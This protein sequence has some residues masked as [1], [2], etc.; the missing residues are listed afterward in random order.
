MTV[1]SNT[2]LSIDKVVFTPSSDLDLSNLEISKTTATA[3]TSTISNVTKVLSFSNKFSYTGLIN[4][5]YLDA[6]LNGLTEADL[7]F[8]YYNN[9][10]WYPQINSSVITETNTVSYT[11]TNDNFDII[12]LQ[13][14]NKVT[15]T[16][17]TSDLTKTYGDNDFS[18]DSSVLSS[19]SDGEITYRSSNSSIASITGSTVSILSAGSVVISANQTST[20]DFEAGTTSFTLTILK[21]DPGLSISNSSKI[22]NDTDFSISA[23]SSSGGAIAYLIADSSVATISGTTV[24]II[25]AGSTII[26]VSQSATTNYNSSTATATLTVSKDSPTLSGLS[27]MT[28]NYGDSDFSLSASSSSTGAITYS[29][30]DNSVATIS[31]TTVTIVGAGSAII[32]VLQVADNNYNSATLTA[33]LTVSKDSPTLSGLSDMTKNYGD[34]DFSLSASSP[35]TGAIMYSSSDTSVATI[36][37]TT[38]TIVGAGS[39]IITASQTADDNYNSATTTVTLTVSKDSPTLSGLSNIS[40]TYGD[41]DFSL[42]ASSSSTGAIT[43]SSSDNSVATISGTTVTIVGAGSAIITASQTA[44]DNY[45][46][47]TITASLT[48]QKDEAPI[49]GYDNITNYLHD[50]TISL[51]ASSSSTALIT[52]SSSD[53]SIATISGST[54]IPKSAGEA[55][56]TI[57]QVGDQNYLSSMASFSLT[58]LSGNPEIS[59]FNDIDKTYNDPTFELNASSTSSGTISYSS[60]NS[61]VATI[62]GTTVSI[63]GAGTATILLEQDS[64]DTYLAATQSI[65]LRVAKDDPTILFE[66]LTK[67]YN[68]NDFSLSATSSSTGSITFSSSDTSVASISGSTVTIVGAGNA[69][70]TAS[71]AADSNYN[72]A[73]NTASLTVI[74]DIPTI[75]TSNIVRSYDDEDF[76]ITTD[77]VSSTSSAGFFYTSSNNSVATVSGDT[78]SIVSGGSTIITVSQAATSNYESATAS[79]TLE[80]NQIASSLQFDDLEKTYGDA[81]FELSPITNS[82]GAIS[83]SS[84]K[85]SVATVSG[86]IVSIHGA[87]STTINLVQEADANYETRTTSMT[88]RVAQRQLRVKGILVNDKIYDGTTSATVDLSGV[89]FEG[90]LDRDA[91][92]IE[93]HGAFIDASASNSKTVTLTSKYSGS[94]LSNYNITDQTIAKATITPKPLYLS[95]AESIEKIYDGTT[96]LPSTS[97]G[98]QKL[99]GLIEGDDVIIVGKPSFD[100]KEVGNRSIVQSTL[101][102]SGIKAPNYNLVWTNGSGKITQKDLFI[103][104]KNDAKFVTL[105]DSAGYRGA[106]FSGFVPGES[107]ADLNGSLTIER[108]NPEIELAD[109]Y[110]KVLKP[111]GYSSNNYNLIY[112]NGNYTIVPADFLLLNVETDDT[113]Y[114]EIPTYTIRGSYLS[115]TTSNVVYLNNPIYNSKSKRYTL[116]D[117]A[118]GSVSFEITAAPMITTTGKAVRPVSKSGYIQSGTYALEA[119]NVLIESNNFQKEVVT[120]GAITIIPKPVVAKLINPV[121]IYDGGV[122]VPNQEM[123]IEG[124]IEGDE[125]T[126]DYSGIFH[127]AEV[128]TSIGYTL[129][130]INLSGNDQISYVLSSTTF[131]GTDGRIDKAPLQVNA[132]AV[133]KTYN[134]KSLSN[135]SHEFIGFAAGENATNLEGSLTYSGVGTTAIDVGTY[136]YTLSG[137]SSSNYEISYGESTLTINPAPIQVSGIKVLDK[138][139]DGTTKASVDLT[140]VYYNGLISGETIKLQATALF[141]TATAGVFKK[142]LI[143]SIYSG[144]D[145]LNY[146]ITDQLSTTATIDKAPLTVQVTSN[147]IQYL[148]IPYTNFSV[149]YEGFVNSEDQS[150]LAGTI[151]YYGDATSAINKGTYQVNAR[152]LSSDNYQINYLPGTL[153]IVDGDLDGDGI[154][155]SSDDDIDGDGI[156][157]NADVDIDNNGIY[158]NGTDFDG[159]GIN[160]TYD[161]DDDGD[162]VLDTQDSFPYNQLEWVDTDGDGIGNNEDTDDDNDG[163]LD[164]HEIACQS[165][166]ID[167]NESAIDTDGDHLPNCIDTDDDGD[168]V[169]DINDLF[170][171]IAS[172]SL[173]TDED[174]IGNNSD[175]D[176]DNDG[177]LDIHEL[178]CFSDPLNSNEIAL[179]SDGDRI[180][181]CIDTDDDNDGLSDLEEVEVGTNPLLVDTDNDGVIDSVELEDQ[182]DPLDANSLELNHQTQEEGILNWSGLDPDGDGIDNIYEVREH[183]NS[184]TRDTQL[185]FIDTDGDG[186]YDYLDADDDGDGILTIDENADPNSDGNPSDAKDFDADQIPNYL[187]ADDDNDGTPTAVELVLGTNHLD[188]DTDDDGVT[189]SQEIADQTDPL[190]ACSLMVNHQTE[191]T[192]WWNVQ[193]CDSDGLSNLEESG[194]DSDNDGLENFIDSDDDGDGLATLLENADLA[195]DA[196]NDGTPDYL[197]FNNFEDSPTV[198]DD[199]E[200]YNAMSPNG[201]GHNDVFVIRNI[202][203]YPDN[204]LIIFNRWGKE[205]YRKEAYGTYNRFYDGVDM[206]GQTLPVGTYYYILKVIANGSEENFKGFLYINR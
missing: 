200:I 118:G 55:I 171:L 180:P 168:G 90:L 143:T 16:Y 176:D 149:S 169:L 67:T 73:T 70:I 124:L 167:A 172:E 65:T 88:L 71:Q 20:N 150:Q 145:Q 81:D 72:S 159:D 157:N 117:N 146:S 66:D 13:V 92:S 115:S 53:S 153:T 163:M 148:G 36:S 166:P 178:E 113:I 160:D 137:F 187:D 3:E 130:E 7:Q 161:L 22:F 89:V 15:P 50:G 132:N 26:S 54:I 87:G 174:G 25:G 94:A 21:A 162:G 6:E 69:V 105:E 45:N 195:L 128:G 24:S 111:S 203:K 119:I 62:S 103:I 47:A 185:E 96:T 188:S 1:K 44:V 184:N 18:I 134:G 204:Q 28:K 144:D 29:S 112:I 86:S 205:V 183:T 151:E 63:Q 31:G 138:V 82:T 135:L 42:S 141:E 10:S 49:K 106:S 129:S 108:V 11:A 186:I 131:I 60:S 37:G 80:V 114:A 194:I 165:N 164:I 140:E 38:V 154:G 98:Y 123:S 156:E 191:N 27:N 175:P 206:N 99:D 199:I 30:S 14:Y 201:D 75:N 4:Y 173:D 91:I 181:D 109:S 100:S 152:G 51:S 9:S 198:A 32:T 102:I 79:F 177:Q 8:S 139:Y 120:V 125:L 43:Y 19:T 61:S 93:T 58:L 155:D 33:S 126:A 197:D 97:S 56:I 133:S 78:I 83:Y 158:D 39:A 95:G 127:Q 12:T 48:V 196:D 35:S 5:T 202:E 147:S 34:D 41:S 17:T 84:S 192:S 121:K 107:K 110:T 122:G 182:T 57:S 193:D 77:I 23:S 68:D 116:T 74:K 2:T 59:S 190:E 101:S 85:E 52:Y 46:S 189:D 104:A 170:P 64:Y 136:S 142:A 179:D 76:E 40:K